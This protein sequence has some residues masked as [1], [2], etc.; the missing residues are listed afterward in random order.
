MPLDLIGNL[1]KPQLL[2]AE[3]PS[4]SRTRRRNTLKVPTIA[5]GTIKAR[6]PCRGDASITGDD[7]FQA[8][9][10][11]G[12][13]ASNHH[14]T[15]MPMVIGHET[16]QARKRAITGWNGFTRGLLGM[17]VTGLARSRCAPRAHQ[18]QR[19]AVS[20]RSTNRTVRQSRVQG[21]VSRTDSVRSHHRAAQS[22]ADVPRS[23]AR[24][25]E[26]C[27]AHGSTAPPA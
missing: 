15:T 17:T 14:H 8:T 19:P 12:R 20:I 11:A 22:R 16:A 18:Q 6:R 7:V 25:F 10:Q 26:S 4:P 21:W 5:T 9:D 23:R 27:R 24:T 1:G 13:S 2:F 3:H